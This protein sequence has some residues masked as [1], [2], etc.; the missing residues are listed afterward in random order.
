MLNAAILCVDDEI[1]ILKSLEVELR[2]IFADRYIYEFAESATE[3]LEIID[4][5]YTDGIKTLMVV[6]DWLMPGMKGDDLLIQ[7]HQ[8]YPEIITVMLTG[9]ADEQAIERAVTQAKL[10]RCIHKPW[11]ADEL[12]STIHSALA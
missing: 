3:A 2:D 7:V 1:S 4:E 6:S 9:Q 12:R 10:Y 8:N 5:L 11:Q